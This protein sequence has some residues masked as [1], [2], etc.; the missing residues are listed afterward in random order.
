[1]AEPAWLLAKRSAT[2]ALLS[3][4]LTDIVGNIARTHGDSMQ[5]TLQPGEKNLLGF[6]K[7]DIVFFEK[8]SAAA[9]KYHRGDVVV[10]RS[11]SD[12]NQW[13][14]K[15]LIAMQGDWINVPG[16]Y[17]ILQI[18][19]GRCWVEGDGGN[20]S[21]D[22]RTFGALPLGLVQGRV[23]H[24]IWPPHRFGRVERVFPKGRV[25]LDDEV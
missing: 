10:L 4:T 13:M 16:S 11:P 20:I 12:P 15:R 6:L 21:L 1:M 17:E 14:I 23:T 9:Y 2:A 3:I 8:I 7:G 5:P 22:S 25:M 19:K 18:P 24:K